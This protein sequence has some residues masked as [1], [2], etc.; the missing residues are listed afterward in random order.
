MVQGVAVAAYEAL[1]IATIG[2]LYFVHERGPRVSVILFIL[3]SVS[4]FVGIVAGVITSNLGWRYNFHVMLPFSA[5]QTILFVFFAPETMYSRK[6]IY[7]IDMSGSSDDLRELAL[8]EAENARHIEVTNLADQDCINP[9][10]KPAVMLTT[11]STRKPKTFFQ[12]MSIYNGSFVD[13]SIL[14]M[15]IACPAILLN[16]GALYQIVTSGLVTAWYVSLAI[17]TGVVFASPPYLLNSADIGYTSVGPFVG[18]LLGS[19]ACFIIATPMRR[20]LTQ[21]NAGIYEPEFCLLPILPGGLIMIAGLLGFGYGLEN[22][23]NIYLLSFIW[24]VALFGV[25]FIVTFSSQYALD[26]FRNN[27]TEIF[28]MN[29]VFK[30]FFFYG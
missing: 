12:E 1:S 23:D 28:I 17:L 2:D 16:V 15:L 27:S 3:S 8:K 13:D 14:K 6:A 19:S 7:D 29:M 21:K 4:N 22:F 30:N 10:E 11:Q 20:W 25:S 9:K 24:G 26:A 5:L 18:G